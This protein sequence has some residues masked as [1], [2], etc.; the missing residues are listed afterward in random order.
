MGWTRRLNWSVV[1]GGV[2]CALILLSAVLAPLLTTYGVNEPDLAVVSS[3]PGEEGHLLG[4]DAIGRDL[5]TRIMYGGRISLVVA[6]V[7]MLGSMSVGILTG[8]LAA[9]GGRWV[10]LAML[11]LIDV[12]LA[13]P[14]VLLAIAITSAVKP[15]ISVLILLMVL[16]GWAAAARVV[17]SVA[18]QQASRDYVKAATVVGASRFRIATKYVFP[19]IVPAILV[20]A[21]LQMAAMIVFESTLS[22]LGM[23][24]QPPTPSWGGIMLEG[25]DYM[26]SAWWLVTLPGVAIFLTA[27]GLILVA[28]GLQTKLETSVDEL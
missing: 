18:V 15:S 7:G 20:L 21:P 5:L 4:T 1:L 10:E 22:F 17:R 9:F 14:Y 23:G 16:A 26:A 8:L 12:Q 13:F 11:R 24:I 6:G 19:S 28:E 3:P 2:L 27:L 25:K